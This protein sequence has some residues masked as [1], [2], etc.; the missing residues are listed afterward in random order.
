MNSMHILSCAVFKLES[1]ALCAVIVSRPCLCKGSSVSTLTLCVDLINGTYGCENDR[2]MN[3]ILKY[4]YG[5]QGYVVTD[6]GAKF[7]TE[8][9]MSGLDVRRDIHIVL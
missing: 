8:A 3:G 6:W 7:S 4:E 5:F 1:Q 2:L 9:A